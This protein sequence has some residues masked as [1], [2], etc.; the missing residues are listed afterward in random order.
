MPDLSVDLNGLELANPVIAASGTCG[1][2]LEL[3]DFLDLG[4][5]GGVSV[6][7]IS[8]RPHEGNPPPRIVETPAGMLNAIG[9]QNVGAEAFAAEKLPRLRELGATVIV[10][11]WGNEID[12]F[13]AVVERLDGEDGI[14]AYELNVSCPNISREW[15]EFGINP[16]L[17]REL[18]GRV[19]EATG[20]HLMV[21]LSPSA[22]DIAAVGRAAEDSGADSLSAINTILGLEIDL[23]RRR[24]ALWKGTGGL[25]GPAIRPVALRCVWQLYQAVS[26]PVVG[27]GGILALEDALKFFYAGAAAVQV[28]T[29]SFVDPTT[30]I[31]LIDDLERWC[32]EQGVERISDL[33]G[34]A[35]EK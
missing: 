10:N 33:V 27:I 6:K 18:V 19:R 29:A 28:G 14:A 31:R 8:L 4:K 17:T 1:Y 32:A 2:G 12:D 35:H 3:T 26:I 23:E 34:I 22:A 16:E 11:V 30:S 25:S 13:V 9:L 15:I 20:R 24:P 5:L 7:G 21:K